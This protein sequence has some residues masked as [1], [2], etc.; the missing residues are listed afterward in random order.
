M[1]PRSR[2]GDE[3]WAPEAPVR[4]P[5]NEV[6]M[7]STLLSVFFT[8]LIAVGPSCASSSGRPAGSGG[9]P[10]S[11]GASASGGAPA[12]GGA[13]SAGGS[14]SSI[15]S[16][17]D[18]GPG[19]TSG[20]GGAQQG[21]GA[22][23]TGGTPDSGG[24][25]SEGGKQGTGGA[26]STGGKQGSGG[27][28]A[29][30]GA[31]ASGGAGAAV[32]TG[33]TATGDGGRDVPAKDDS[34]LADLRDSQ[35]VSLDSSIRTRQI[36]ARGFTFDALEAGSDGEPVL[37][38]HG[39]PD[40]SLE[41]AGLM[42]VLAAAG[43]HC[44]APDQRGYSPGARPAEVDAYKY[45]ELVADAFAFG[46]EL[47]ERFHLI[48]HDWGAN[49][50]WLMLQ[51][52]P[53]RIASYTSLAV[54]HYQVWARAVYNDP[55]MAGYLSM[56]NTWMTPGKGEAFW[57]ASAMRN[58]WTAKP[59]DLREATIAHM[60]EPGAMTAALNWYRASDGHKAVLNDFAPWEVDV[61][62]LLIFGSDDIGQN[63]VTD[64]KALMTG[65]FRVVQPKGGHFIV[66]EQPQ[67]V[68]DETL[69]HLRAYPIK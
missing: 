12:S 32:G 24:T 46:S 8:A 58:M 20:A 2:R 38:L 50:A 69:A 55:D 34:P 49:I 42:P 31:L 67:I 35:G 4:P 47:G 40:T 44:L 16:G 13:S 33:G 23:G 63:T 65:F 41:W 56:L 30:G 48:A 21:G 62:T 6:G 37:L 29:T 5:S 18:R 39:F 43:Y 3:E 53:S 52:D 19:G 59:A 17:G 60:T 9:A 27:A 36:T 57:T 61:P 45:E 1:A 7:K 22:H 14:T 68:A 10:G 11:G 54:P 25:P 51:K 26:V 66:D 64:T 28:G 15:G